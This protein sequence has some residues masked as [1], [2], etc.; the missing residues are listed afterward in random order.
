M[1]ANGGTR[2]LDKAKIGEL[3][4]REERT[5]AEAEAES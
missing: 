4:K 5:K 2:R 3:T 1:K